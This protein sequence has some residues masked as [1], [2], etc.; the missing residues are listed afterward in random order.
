MIVMSLPIIGRQINIIRSFRLYIWR[1]LLQQNSQNDHQPQS[2]IGRSCFAT[3]NRFCETSL[4]PCGRREV[5]QK[6]FASN[7]ALR[8]SRT[9]GVRAVTS[10][11]PFGGKGRVGGLVI[12]QSKKYNKLWKCLFLMMRCMSM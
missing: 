7:S 8:A 9:R 10:C 3:Q 5:S 2:T 6:R 12:N 1:I 11:C 4:R